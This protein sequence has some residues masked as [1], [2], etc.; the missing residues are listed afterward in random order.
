MTSRYEGKPMLRLLECYVL[1]AI[2]ELDASQQSM[3]YEM[4]QKLQLTYGLQG[5][6]QEI[7]VSVMELPSNMSDLIRGMWKKNQAIAQ[8]KGLPLS[9]QQFA[10]M[11]V[12]QNF[13]S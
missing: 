5:Q 10:E 2:D 3:L 8:K 7:I 4:T 12:D 13:V 9:P 6:W 1:W 11:L